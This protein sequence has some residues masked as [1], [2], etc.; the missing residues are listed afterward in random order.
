MEKVKIAILKN[1]DPYEHLPWVKACEDNREHLMHRVIDLTAKDWLDRINEYQPD[2]CVLKPSGITTIYR[3]LYLERVDILAHD[4]GLKIIPFY[5]E[6]RLYENKK[7][8]AYWLAAHGIPHP[9]TSVFYQRAEAEQFIKSSSFPLVAKI[10]IGASGKGVVVLKN[11]QAGMNYVNQ[12]FTTGIVSKTGPNLIKKKLFTRVLSKL[13]HPQQLLNRLKIYK[14]IAQDRQ[15]GMVILQEYVPHD[16]E[17]RAVR[18]GDSFFA[19]KKMKV[20]EMASGTL[21][22]D[23]GN[24]PLELLDFVKEITDCF[25]FRSVAIDIFDS[26]ER[27]YL[28]NEIQCIFGQSDEFQMLVDGKEG[29]YRYLD[30]GW[31]FEAGDYARN[32]CYNLRLEYVLSCLKEDT[33]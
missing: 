2:A 7:F 31:V 26:R 29:R 6:L 17:W 15:S 12:A 25:G 1:E 16:Y 9:G 27:G 22:K 24:P 19:H 32:A 30:R 11:L 10:N 3:E 20:G 21:I 4:L 18:I 33:I 28:V 8:L 5:S 14:A 23:Y 13:L